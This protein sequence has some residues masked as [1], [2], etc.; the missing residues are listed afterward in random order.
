MVTLSIASLNLR[1]DYQQYSIVSADIDSCL[2]MLT[3]LTK[4]DCHL[5]SANLVLDNEKPTPLPIEAF[6]GEPM[7]EALQML[8]LEWEEVLVKAGRLN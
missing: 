4:A 2:D 7:Q 1:G 3:Y 8:Q 6:D 5:L